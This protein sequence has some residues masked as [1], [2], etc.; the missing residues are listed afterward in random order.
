MMNGIPPNSGMNVRLNVLSIVS[1]SPE[2]RQI[3][4]S[5]LPKR[6]PLCLAPEKQTHPLLNPSKSL[7]RLMSKAKADQSL[8]TKNE[9]DQTNPTKPSLKAKK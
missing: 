8:R 9:K 7:K 5:N 1:V 2:I 4:E 6:H 3:Y